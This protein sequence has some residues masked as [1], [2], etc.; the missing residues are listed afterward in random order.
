[1][2]ADLMTCVRV[3]PHYVRVIFDHKEDRTRFTPCQLTGNEAGASAQ[4]E[5]HPVRHPVAA[6]EV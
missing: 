4:V 2:Q 5:R 3:V 6:F 1:V